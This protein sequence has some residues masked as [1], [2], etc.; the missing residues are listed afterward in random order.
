M[1]RTFMSFACLTALW[2]AGVAPSFGQDDKPSAKEQETKLIAVLKSEAPQKEKSDACRE[3]A[4]IGTKNAVAPLADLLGDEKLS[5]MARYGLEPNPDPAV[6]EALRAALEKLKGRP[7]VGTIGSIGVRRDVKAVEALSKL[8][9]NTD[10]TVVQATARAL[11]LI[12]TAAAAKA[13]EDNLSATPAANR[14]AHYEGL[15][16]SA[17]A[18]TGRGQRGE[19]IATYQALEIY[20]RLARTDVPQQVRESASR[21][22]RVLRQEQGPRL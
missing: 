12:G 1:K 14:R 18:L 9:R 6:D 17:E 11:G 19:P 3:L 10:S 7:L 20:E 15:F 4:L 13:L 8:L 5:H 22:A 2:V 16:R 21:K